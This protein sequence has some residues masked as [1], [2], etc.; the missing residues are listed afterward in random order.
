MLPICVIL[1]KGSAFTL[2][3]KV[4]TETYKLEDLSKSEFVA[5]VYTRYGRKLYS[6]AIKSWSLDE[7]TAWDLVYKTIFKVHE[8]YRNYTFESEARFG[9]MVFRIFI[10]Y[11][12]NHYRDT[13]EEKQLQFSVIEEIREDTGTADEKEEHTNV[14]LAA[15][16]EELEMMEDWQRVLLLMRSDGIPYSKIAEFVDKPE[17]Q[18]KVYY[19]RLKEQITKKLN[20]R[21]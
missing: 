16:N 11:L 12:R 2:V 18:L 20:E 9:S 8:S 7:D 17:G 3:S 15:L 13:R 19:Q 14:K 4:F 21:L 1:I 10:N 5:E 6:Y